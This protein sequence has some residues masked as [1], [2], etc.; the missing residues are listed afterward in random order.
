[1]KTGILAL[2]ILLL[3]SVAD[4]QI[5]PPQE[6]QFAAAGA[7]IMQTTPPVFSVGRALRA[8]WP[9]NVD[10]VTANVTVYR[11]RV[12][13]TIVDVPGPVR[14]PSYAYDIPQALL[15]AG[16]H[17]AGL[18]AC[19]PHVQ[20][21][22]IECG[23]EGTMDF[24]IDRPLPA[25]PTLSIAPVTPNMAL[26]RR[27]GEELVDAYARVAIMRQLSRREWDEVEQRHGDV[28]ITR[29]SIFRVMDTWFL[30]HAR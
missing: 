23:E 28:P 20:T 11:F 13:T 17:Q 14:Q 25:R 2:G 12:D 18:R 21:G 15:T 29:E 27:Q 4:A 30:E 1:M 6:L 16:S 3:A 26:N 7:A 10:E 5:Q 19:R 9:A 8:T 24:V 22:A